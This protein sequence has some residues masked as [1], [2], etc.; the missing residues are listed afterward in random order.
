MDGN[1]ELNA[2]QV[3]DL[4]E[5]VYKDNNRLSYHY[6]VERFNLKEFQIDSL[7]KKADINQQIKNLSEYKVIIIAKPTVAF[8]ML[9]KYIIDQYAMNG[10]KIIW[11]IEEHY[12]YIQK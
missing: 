2:S 7:S 3:Y 6:I 8:N 11:F 5:S 10:G 12:C 9:D 1:G 4:T